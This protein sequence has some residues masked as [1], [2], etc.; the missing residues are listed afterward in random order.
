MAI[1][2]NRPDWVLEL[3]KNGA[4]FEIAKAS[5][6]TAKASYETAKASF[7]TAN[8]SYETAEASFKTAKASYEAAKDIKYDKENSVDYTEM[9][10]EDGTA[11]ATS[12]FNRYY[13]PEQAFKILGAGDKTYW[14]SKY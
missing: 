1:R 12:T 6:E 4:S 5:Y 11:F 10:A 14:C 2:Q 13:R 7:K 8:A 9:R 3:L